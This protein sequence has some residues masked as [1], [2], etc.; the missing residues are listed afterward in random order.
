MRKPVER[1]LMDSGPHCVL[2]QDAVDTLAKHGLTAYRLAQGVVEW[3]LEGSKFEAYKS[4][5]IA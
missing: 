1:V 2:S 4:E 5:N 3:K